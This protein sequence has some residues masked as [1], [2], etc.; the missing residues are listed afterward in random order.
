MAEWMWPA[1]VAS[2]A[3]A[4]LCYFTAFRLHLRVERLHPGFNEQMRHLCSI[5]HRWGIKK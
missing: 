3:L 4:L 1:F 5:L 2:I